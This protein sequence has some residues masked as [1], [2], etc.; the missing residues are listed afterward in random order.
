LIAQSGLLLVSWQ[1]QDNITNSWNRVF[2]QQMVATHLEILCCNGIRKCV[3]AFGKPRYLALIPNS[4]H[5]PPHF[6]KDQYW[7]HMQGAD[8]FSSLH[9]WARSGADPTEDDRLVIQ[10]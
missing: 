10:V 1:C 3:H 2:G 4:S 9:V 6:F 7:C 8:V 5:S